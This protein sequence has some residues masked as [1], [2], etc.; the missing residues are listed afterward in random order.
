MISYFQAVVIGLLQGVTELFHV[1]S[2][3]HSVLVPAW[4]FKGYDA[5]LAVDIGGTN[6]RAGVVELNLKKAADL[7]KAGVWKF[8]LWRH[9]DDKKID[10]EGGSISSETNLDYKYDIGAEVGGPIVGPPAT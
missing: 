9:G 2:L 3:G 7:S 1:S 4:L 6:I 8:D 5:I 10:R